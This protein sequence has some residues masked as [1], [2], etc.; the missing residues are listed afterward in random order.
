MRFLPPITWHQHRSVIALV[1][2]MLIVGLFH[3]AD[4]SMSYISPLILIET[5]QSTT[6]MGVVLG[7]S[8][9]MGLLADAWLSQR[10][11]DRT[12]LF[13][14]VRTFLL[15]PLFPLALLF[16]A[17]WLTF[18]AAMAVWGIYFELMSFSHFKF[19]VSYVKR[20]QYSLAWGLL[21]TF[22]AITLCIGPLLTSW[23]LT[24][25]FRLSLSVSL[26]LF[27]LSLCVV[28]IFQKMGLFYKH[29]HKQA[30]NNATDISTIQKPSNLQCFLALGR[31]V[32]PVWLFL[33]TL[34][35]LDATFWSIGTLFSEQLKHTHPL[36]GFVLTAYILPSF[37]V[38][39]LAKYMAR[40]FGKKRTA[41]FSAALGGG[42]LLMLSLVTNPLSIIALIAL[43]S[44]LGGIAFPE[45][46]ATFEDY[47]DRLD[48]HGGEMIAL[49]R[50]AVNAAYI[51]GP[52][53]A[54]AIASIFPYSVT[55]ALMGG[56]L[57]LISLACILIVPRKIKMPAQQLG[58]NYH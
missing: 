40:P 9:L 26:C 56:L 33:F 54:G 36:G 41:F 30:F 17:S 58:L 5:F 23:L 4:S 43:S 14:A 42:A 46:L 44:L 1:A 47:I 57:S 10:T 2:Y 29:T 3:L 51:L 37:G 13:F 38:G 20:E 49:E 19:V 16:G 11:Q 25:G 12:F 53:I 32:W 21:E 18:I 34:V 7:L 8:S 27:A 6:L 45:I 52:M 24:Y 22:K 15:A 48:Q 55:I 28:V 35:M 31:R 39:L 50:S